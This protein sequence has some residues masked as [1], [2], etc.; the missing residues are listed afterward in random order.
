M[1]EYITKAS[2][3]NRID[4]CSFI[5]RQNDLCTWFTKETVF[6]LQSNT[7]NKP[8]FESTFKIPIVS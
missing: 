2:K 4:L 3:N 5:I 1:Y 7:D 6:K 8:Q